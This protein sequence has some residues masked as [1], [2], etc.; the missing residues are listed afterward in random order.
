MNSAP[1]RY[2][3]IDDPEY[4]LSL[5]SHIEAGHELWIARYNRVDN[6]TISLVI[7]YGCGIVFSEPGQQSCLVDLQDTPNSGG[8]FMI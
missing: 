3:E 5:T 1:V 4:L 8:T 6:Q 7:I 2:N